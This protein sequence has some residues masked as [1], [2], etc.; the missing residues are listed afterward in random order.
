MKPVVAVV[1]TWIAPGAGHWYLG[2]RK[3]AIFYFVL[4]TGLYL[5]GMAIADFRNINL[6]R[7]P[8][9]FLTYIF[10]G[11]ATLLAQ[12]LTQG[13][14][15]VRPLERLDVGCLYSAVA[16]LLNILVMIDAYLFASGYSAHA[17]DS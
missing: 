16:G 8:F 17:A 10:Y 7:H 3:K 6:D 1:L 15:M 14:A 11:G 13:L 2:N 9:F 5:A 12:I 4:L